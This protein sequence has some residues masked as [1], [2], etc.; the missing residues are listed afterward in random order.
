MLIE[1]PLT[2]SLDSDRFQ[3]IVE[4][5]IHE[6]CILLSHEKLA[7]S[8]VRLVEGF[9]VASASPIRNFKE[10]K[11]LDIHKAGLEN[12]LIEV[13]LLTIIQTS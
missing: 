8:V 13:I 6:M 7:S 1:Q 12:L 4:V 9:Q 2:P 10:G 11:Y 5:V 3:T